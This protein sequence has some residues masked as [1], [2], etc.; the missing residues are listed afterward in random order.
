[1]LSGGRLLAAEVE[2]SLEAT[3]VIVTPAPL[4]GCFP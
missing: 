3:A 4:S 2:A 1:M